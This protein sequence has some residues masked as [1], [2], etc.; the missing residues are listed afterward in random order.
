MT[1]RHVKRCSAFRCFFSDVQARGYYPA[2]ARRMLAEKGVQLTK[3][4]GDDE[5]LRQHPVDFVSFSSLR[6]APSAPIPS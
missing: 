3:A 2:Y 6:P 4:V 5:I 1:Y